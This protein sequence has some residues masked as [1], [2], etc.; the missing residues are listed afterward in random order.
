M[1]FVAFGCKGF[2]CGHETHVCQD[3][4]VEAS[5]F[6]TQFWVLG[7]YWISAIAVGFS[8]VTGIN[9]LTIEL[10][11]VDDEKMGGLTTPTPVTDYMTAWV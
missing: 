10:N 11:Q 2:Y 3:G 4:R 6:R 8:A 1:R 7:A 9:M 5:G